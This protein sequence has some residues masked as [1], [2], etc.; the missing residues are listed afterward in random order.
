MG[1]ALRTYGKASLPSVDG[2]G[3]NNNI[4]KDP[5]KSI[6]TRRVDKVGDNN[7]ITDQIDCASDRI[8]EGISV[9]ARGV[10]P[11]V[12][13][14]YTNQGVSSVGGSGN[15][16]GMANS[17]KGS[18]GKLPIRIMQDG[19]FRPPIIPQEQQV[20]L[21]RQPRLAT[22]CI[23]NPQAID[24]TK[25]AQ[26]MDLNKIVKEKVIKANIRPTAVYRIEKP[27]QQHYSTPFIKQDPLQICGYSGT[28]S[29]D[30]S[31]TQ[32]LAP[33]S[34][35]VADNSLNTKYV[36][37]NIYN[38]RTE[39]N[40]CRT[41][42]QEGM[43][44]NDEIAHLYVNANPNGQLRD[45]ELSVDLKR[46]TQNVIQFERD[47][48][49]LKEMNVT[50]IEDMGDITKSLKNPVKTVGRTGVR[51][52]DKTE[53]IH[54]PLQLERKGVADTFNTNAG[55]GGIGT[56]AFANSSR[57]ATLPERRSLGGF[58]NAGFQPVIDERSMNFQ[59]MGNVSDQR[60]AFNNSIVNAQQGRFSQ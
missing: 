37:T 49:R 45:G 60:A 29:L 17:T 36:Q 18:G 19:A 39:D 42:Q 41:L 12:S 46:H 6:H 24:Y 44:V 15:R 50:G 26:C 22:Q 55:S 5:P 1:S 35:I 38:D 58:S 20:A 25:R 10:N 59:K 53:Y 2:W 57:S 9:Y 33:K 48:K 40:T 54:Q 4:V 30:W 23:T 7:S 51:G 31:Q 3:T 28:R 14:N 21:S 43:F 27:I 13:V 11:M 8:C 56:D 47:S 32:H 34:G 52:Q 16:G